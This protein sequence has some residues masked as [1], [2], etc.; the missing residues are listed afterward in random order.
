MGE[1]MGP[2]ELTTHG[3]C[4]DCLEKELSKS[5][6]REDRLADLCKSWEELY[7]RDCPRPSPEAGDMDEEEMDLDDLDDLELRQARAEAYGEDR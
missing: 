4:K 6:R 5:Y 7:R 3:I 2:D 1:K